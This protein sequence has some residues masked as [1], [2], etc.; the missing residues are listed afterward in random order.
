MMREEI[1][2]RKILYEIVR[3]LFSNNK[4][5]RKFKS[6]KL[7]VNVVMREETLVQIIVEIF[8][9]NRIR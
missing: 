2:V 7:E 3:S 9:V 8:V 6:L 4:F 5:K 1:L